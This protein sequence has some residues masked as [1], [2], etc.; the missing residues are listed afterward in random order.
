M[1]W[2]IEFSNRADKFARKHGLLDTVTELIVTFLR[3]RNDMDV[4]VLK[5][6]WKGY[7]R[8]RHSDIRVIFDLDTEKRIVFVD[9]IA[10]RDN[11]YR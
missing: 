4:K 2:R 8:I 5:G 6:K 1:K 10:R 11:A 9:T 7:H 3:V